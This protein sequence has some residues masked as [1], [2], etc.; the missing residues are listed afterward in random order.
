MMSVEVLGTGP[1][2]RRHI[3]VV[4]TNGLQL[5]GVLDIQKSSLAA[6]TKQNGVPPKLV[7]DDLDILYAASIP[8]CVIAATTA[9]SDADLVCDAI[10][11]GVKCAFG[12]K[13]TAIPYDIAF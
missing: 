12:E 10:E 1:M 4:C 9:P 3:E 6:A 5:Y 11:R 8:D 7:F 13:S 2:G